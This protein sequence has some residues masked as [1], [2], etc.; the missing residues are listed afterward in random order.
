MT[1]QLPPAPSASALLRQ[2][3]GTLAAAGIPDPRRE[4]R[5]LL[6]HAAG[7]DQAALLRDMHGV[8]AAPGFA[9]MVERRA[10]R[11]PLA[12]ITGRQGFWSLDLAVSADTLIPRT[13]SEAVV[14]AALAACA[15]RSVRRILDL[16]TGTGCLLLALLSE[17]PGA[18]GVG[19]DRAEGAARLARRNAAA[20]GLAARTMLLCAD[21]GAPLDARFDLVV[22]NPPYIESAAMAKLMPEVGLWEPRRALDGGVDG[23]DAYRAII[24]A[25]QGLL[26]PD[27]AA[28][29]ELGQGQAGPV[30][31]M[32][33]AHGLVLAGLHDDLSG[34]A[35]AIAVRPKPR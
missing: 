24:A 2:A 4:A 28:V 15:G 9:A 12:L 29:L 18:V 8:L 35:R 16:G 34:I 19:V 11:E 10:A 17:C 23:L 1:I 21:W 32:A 25:L 3:A 30:G 22:S 31:A 27:G 26:T 6:A 14:E 13:D 7:V 20:V 33:Q 5:L